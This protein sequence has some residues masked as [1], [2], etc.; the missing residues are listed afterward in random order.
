MCPVLTHLRSFRKLTFKTVLLSIL[1]RENFM[2]MPQI[3]RTQLGFKKKLF[4]LPFDH[5]GSF[6]EKLFGI[7]GRAPTPEE[8]QDIASYKKIIFD[9][10]KK[11]VAAGVPKDKAGILVDEQFGTEILKNAKSE[12]F[13]TACPAEKSGQEEFDFEYGEEFGSH[14]NKFGPTF[15][16]V[17]VRYNPQGDADMNLRQAERLKRLSD[18]CHSH[19]CKF[20]FELLVPATPEQLTSV[21]GDVA[22]YDKELRPAL[23]VQAMKH[24]QD[25][26]MEADLWKLEGIDSVE[27]SKK[28]AA[29]ARVGGR[30]DVGVIVLGRGENAEKVKHWLTTAAKVPGLIGFAVGRTVF[31]EPLKAVKDGKI[32]REEASNRIALTYK[33]FCDLWT[34]AQS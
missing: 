30:S 27:D 3:D 31:W 18:Y 20:M 14:I 19:H 26:G 28:V 9:G 34:H 10:F 24:L 8:T 13:M 7:K 16:K 2:G 29:Q 23:M 6:Q 12:G 15:V 5:R 22:R 11:A 33:G 21:G 25:F 17:L 32:T 1:A 4:I